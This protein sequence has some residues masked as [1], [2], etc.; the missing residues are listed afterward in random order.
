V[1]SN[2]AYTRIVFRVVDEDARRV[3]DG[4]AFFVAE[5]IVALG[6]G[7]A[8]VRAGRADQDFNSQIPTPKKATLRHTR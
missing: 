1:I 6:R 7:E 4:F 3:A 5:D 8:I 2:N